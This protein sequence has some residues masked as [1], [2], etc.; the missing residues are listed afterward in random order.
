MPKARRRTLSHCDINNFLTEI[1][2]V[3]DVKPQKIAFD[4]IISSSTT[5]IFTSNEEIKQ[6]DEVSLI[7]DYCKVKVIIFTMLLLFLQSICM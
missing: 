2:T 1:S 3:A 6:K 5:T 4:E 7:R